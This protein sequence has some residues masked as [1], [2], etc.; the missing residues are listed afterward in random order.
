M[1]T[2]KYK[3]SWDEDNQRERVDTVQGFFNMYDWDLSM[4]LST[5]LYGFYIP[6]RKIFGNKIDRIRHVFTPNVS[7]SYAPGFGAEHYGYY[8]HYVKVDKEGNSTLVEYSPYSGTLYSPPSK[9]MRGS[10]SMSISNNVEMKYRN[11]DDSLVKVSLIDELGA[12]MSYFEEL[13]LQS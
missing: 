1:L 4:S 12:Q 13:H 2:Q 8:D 11:K 6:S 5:K 9:D 10:M 3:R 7:F